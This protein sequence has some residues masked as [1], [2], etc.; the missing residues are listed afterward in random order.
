MD[1]LLGEAE[2][3]EGLFSDIVGKAV[4]GADKGLGEQTG[5]G[6]KGHPAQWWV[7]PVGRRRE[8]HLRLLWSNDR[9]DKKAECG[10]PHAPDVDLLPSLLLTSLPG[11]QRLMDEVQSR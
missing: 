10:N 5:K 4:S 9:P 2:S 6:T 8:K 11:K 1:I 3:L 7:S